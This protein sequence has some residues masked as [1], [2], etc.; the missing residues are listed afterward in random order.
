L[1][2]VDTDALGELLLGEALFLAQFGYA[3]MVEPC[4]IRYSM[5]IL[6]PV[7]SISCIRNAPAIDPLQQAGSKH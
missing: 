3:G 1:L 6:P 5:H 4:Q 2:N 7:K